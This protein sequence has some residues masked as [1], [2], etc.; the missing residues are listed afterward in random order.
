MRCRALLQSAAPRT[1]ARPLHL[2]GHGATRPMFQSVV[3]SAKAASATATATRGGAVSG[4]GGGGG[5]RA[6]RIATCSS[7]SSDPSSSSG[8]A[9][10]RRWDEVARVAVA[11]T[12]DILSPRAQAPNLS[13]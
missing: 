7:P 2:T 5:G 9:P 11:T 3:T 13:P 10:T 4:R 12:R 8:S 1:A 6:A